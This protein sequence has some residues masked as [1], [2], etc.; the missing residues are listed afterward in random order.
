MSGGF[1]LQRS[2]SSFLSLQ[3]RLEFDPESTWVARIPEQLPAHRSPCPSMRRLF[4]E[5]SRHGA[6]RGSKTATSLRSLQHADQDK[7]DNQNRQS[8]YKRVAEEHY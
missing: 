3:L 1:L 7:D 4:S 6:S 5:L 8:L 2:S